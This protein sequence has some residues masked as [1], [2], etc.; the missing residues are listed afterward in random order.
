MTAQLSDINNPETLMAL[1]K[2]LR[3]VNYLGAAQL[4]LKDNF[5][6]ESELK[7]EHL[8]QRVLGH[9]GTV[10]GLNFI[11][12]NLYSSKKT[13]PKNNACSW[14]RS[15]LSCPACQSLC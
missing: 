10:P 12:A 6:L 4:Y 11:Y 3:M 15:W 2:Y 9:W 8:K 14:A 13:F 5:L 7:K 1:T